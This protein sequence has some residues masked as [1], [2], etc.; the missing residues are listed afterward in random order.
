MLILFTSSLIGCAKES[1][2]L[3]FKGEGEN[4]RA[5]LL[6]TYTFWG[7][8]LHRIRIQYEGEKNIEELAENSI[9]VKSPDFLGWGIPIVDINTN[10]SFDSGEV[11]KLDTKTPSSA[12][13]TLV[14]EG[15]DSEEL[16]LSS[17]SQ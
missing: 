15:E 9:T 6:T 11:F 10:G 12:S 7:K 5:E 14:I 3:V 1:S 8:E 17:S 4:W 16:L 2:G 13:V